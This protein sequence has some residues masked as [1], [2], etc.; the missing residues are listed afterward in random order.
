M[1]FDPKTASPLGVYLSLPQATQGDSGSIW[2]AHDR[3]EGLRGL[4]K[5]TEEA[6]GAGIRRTSRTL[7][8]GLSAATCRK[9]CYTVTVV[10][11]GIFLDPG[12]SQ[13]L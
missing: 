1:A 2:L 13:A 8:G 3:A 9:G 6:G 12:G 4:A 7:P 10:S 5:I 11:R